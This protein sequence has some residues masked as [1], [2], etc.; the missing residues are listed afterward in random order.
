[1]LNVKKKGEKPSHQI[2]NKSSHESISYEYGKIQM[3][4]IF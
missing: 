1:M 3:R 2:F 4:M